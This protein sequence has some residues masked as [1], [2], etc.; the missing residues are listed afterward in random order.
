[1]HD[2]ES[3]A[4]EIGTYQKVY[5]HTSG[6]AR[7]PP[8]ICFAR[9]S[10]SCFLLMFGACFRGLQFRENLF[11]WTVQRIWAVVFILLARD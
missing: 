3:S 9:E 7:F 8:R 1:M 2:G 4:R 5:S 11:K 6:D 10:H